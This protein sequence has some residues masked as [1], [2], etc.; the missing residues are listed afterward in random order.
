MPASSSFSFLPS[1]SLGQLLSPEKNSLPSFL[2]LIRGEGDNFFPFNFCPPPFRCTAS[3]Y[4]F[5]LLSHFVAFGLFFPFPPLT[6]KRQPP[7]P[8]SPFSRGQ[9]RDLPLYPSVTL[10]SLLPFLPRTTLGS[11]F[12]LPPLSFSR[13]DDQVTPFFSLP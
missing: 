13:K 7:L 3:L 10:P 2:S 8:F 11:L 4:F 12:S 5:L 9:K 6:R 1:A